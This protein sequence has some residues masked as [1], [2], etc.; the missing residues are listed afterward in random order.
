MYKCEYRSVSAYE[1]KSKPIQLGN[2][3]SIRELREIVDVKW[4]GFISL[5]FKF[6]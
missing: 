3:A 5:R 1:N 4:G 2:A 6:D